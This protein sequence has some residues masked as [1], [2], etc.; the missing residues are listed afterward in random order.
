MAEQLWQQ[1]YSGLNE[2][3]PRSQENLYTWSP[4]WDF[5]RLAI[6]SVLF[7]LLLRFHN[8]SFQLSL[9]PWLHFTMMDTIPLELEAQWNAF[10]SKLFWS[11][12]LITATEHTWCWDTMAKPEYLSASIQ[13]W[14]LYPKDGHACNASKSWKC[15][16]DMF[17]ASKQEI[18]NGT[19]WKY[20]HWCFMTT[21]AFHFCTADCIYEGSSVALQTTD[22]E[23]SGISLRAPGS[24]LS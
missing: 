16:N 14:L 6:S 23:V 2:I 15:S 17:L 21:L 7:C 24:S 3:S 1:V 19:L 18:S 5:K 10:F 20:F 9:P 13:W 12:C 8:V 4:F 22:W 11:W